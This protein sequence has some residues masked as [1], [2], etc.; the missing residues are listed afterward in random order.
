MKYIRTKAISAAVLLFFSISILSGCSQNVL[1]S[2]KPLEVSTSPSQQSDSNQHQQTSPDVDSNASDNSNLSSDDKEQSEITSPPTQSSSNGS[3]SEPASPVKKEKKKVKALY[4]TGWT[5]GND[6]NVQHYIDLAKRT[7]INAYVIDIKD[8]DGYVGYESN[9]PAVREIGAWKKKYD[10][11]KVIKAFHDNGIHV[12]GRLVCF[13]DPVLSSK[14]PEFAIKK[15]DGSLWTAKQKTWLDPYKREAWPYIIEIAKEA[16]AKGF[17]EIQ[18][19]YI[20]FAN[21]G[22]KKSMYFGEQELKKYEIINEFISY[23][24]KELPDVILS[25]DVFGII[26]ES[27]GDREDIGQHLE[28]IGKELD[29]ISPMVYPSHYA[30]GQAVNGKVFPKPDLEP[31]QVIYNS[32][33]KAK[34]RISKVEGYQADVRPYLQGFTATWIGKGNYIEYTAKEVRDQI[35]AAY[36]AGYEEWIIWSASNKYGKIEGAFLPEGE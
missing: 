34:N 2:N 25:A 16:V 35:K 6:K 15:K 10:A 17:D 24:R 12:I 23:A 21:D 9:I 19:D 1:S 18:F 14:K 4:L 32:L 31:Y 7:E 11:D 27:P 3:N 29:Y 36:D 30:L 28:F 5:V 22:D 33:V 13:K 8:D 20:R 26:C